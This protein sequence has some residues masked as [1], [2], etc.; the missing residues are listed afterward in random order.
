[1]QHSSAGP[2]VGG[3]GTPVSYFLP[4]QNEGERSAEKAL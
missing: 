1:M 4:P 2:V 3:A